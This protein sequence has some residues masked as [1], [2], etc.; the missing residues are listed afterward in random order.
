MGSMGQMSGMGHH[1]ADVAGG[2]PHPGALTHMA[3]MANASRLA[4]APGVARPK[5]LVAAPGFS[6]TIA[7]LSGGDARGDA[8]VAFAGQAFAAAAHRAAER[9]AAPDAQYDAAAEL[10]GLVPMPVASLMANPA[11]LWRSMQLQMSHGPHAAKEA[12]QQ[13]Q[14][15]F[16]RPR[17]EG[18]PAARQAASAPMAQ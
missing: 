15:A 14:G 2:M 17:E 11:A 16:K 9:A 4:A 8:S 6:P 12:Q 1:G 7:A 13:Q 10:R 18:A 3:A 5:A